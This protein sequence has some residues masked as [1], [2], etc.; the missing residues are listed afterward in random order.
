M[1]LKHIS[2]TAQ[3][4]RRQCVIVFKFCLEKTQVCKCDMLIMPCCKLTTL[5]RKFINKHLHVFVIHNRIEPLLR[6]IDWSSWI[7]IRHMRK[8]HTNVMTNIADNILHNSINLL[9][10]N[11]VSLWQFI[12]RNNDVI[13]STAKYITR[14]LEA[15]CDF[16]EIDIRNIFAELF[17][18]FIKVT[19]HRIN[20][21]LKISL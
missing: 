9:T 1:L 13:P 15:I 14:L 3:L 17:I 16:I 18:N 5:E 8:P 7:A 2:Q 21:L 6:I 19:A 12:F 11:F 20:A 4:L 10:L